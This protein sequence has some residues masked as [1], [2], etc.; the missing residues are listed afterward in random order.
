MY[1]KIIEVGVIFLLMYIPLAFGGVTQSSISL[2]E[3]V[4]GVL[5]IVWLAK[6]LS[7][8]KSVSRNRFLLNNYRLPKALV[9]VAICAFFAV[10]LLQFVPLPGFLV[11]IISPATYRLYAEGALHTG[12]NL[13]NLL[14]LSVCTQATE[15]EFYKFLA[16]TVIFFLIVNTIRTRKQVTRLVYIIL[17]VGLFES[18]YGLL[19]FVS[20]EHLIYS[21]R[22]TWFWVNGTFINKNH[23]A[24][25]LEMVIPLAL[26]VLFTRFEK[27]GSSRLT[28]S[29]DSIREKYPKA[30]LLLLGVLIMIFAL[31]LSGSRGGIISFSLGAIFFALL[32]NT[33][34][35]LRR[36]VVIILIFVPLA[37]GITVI[38][39]QDILIQRLS[40]LTRIETDSSFR[41]RLEFWK[42]AGHIFED[43]P[44]VGSGFGTFAHLSKRYRTFRVQLRH[45]RYP[46]NDYVQ[47]LAETGFVGAS[48]VLLLG[49]AFF[50]QIF[51]TWKRRRSRWAVAMVAG[52][53]SAMFSIAIHS[54][55]DFNLHIPS[56]ALL[57]SVIAALSYVTAHI[58]K[59]RRVEGNT[60][61]SIFPSTGSE[62]RNLQSSI[63]FMV[64]VV[65]AFMFV[66]LYLFYAVNSYYAF[67][68]YQEASKVISQKT[69][70]PVNTTQHDQVIEHLKTAIRHDRNNAEYYYALG[71]YLYRY[72][73]DTQDG[74]AIEHKAQGFH[75]AETWLQKAMRLDPANP[76]YYYEMGRLSDSRGDCPPP[77]S[78]L[79]L[80]QARDRLHQGRRTDSPLPW[81]EGELKEG[82]CPAARYFSAALNNAP[83]EMFLRKE[84][85]RW[86]YYYDQETA[87][88]LLR[89][90][91]SRDRGTTPEH[92]RVSREFSKFLYEIRMDYESDR[93]AAK[94]VDTEK[95]RCKVSVVSQS[96]INLALQGRI[97]FGNDDGSAEWR[98]RLASNTLRVKKVICLPEN[99]AEYDYAALKIFMNHGGNE[100]FIARIS[101]DKHLVKTYDDTAPHIGKWH[102]IP[103][104]KMLLQGKSSIN[105]YI[106]VT[107]ATAAGNYLQIWGDQDTPTTLS[108]FNVDMTNDLSLDEGVQTGEYMIRLVLGTTT[109][110]TTN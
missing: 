89:K 17:A 14:P 46:E 68:H 24:G 54:L 107:G 57:F 71:S 8:Y 97:E 3:I 72:Y 15:G 98:T 96:K 67:T 81:R 33:R 9:P 75:E 40:T 5:L 73:A 34:R 38:I 28:L 12:S 47:L 2:L 20:G 93:E 50:Y 56:N 63:Y 66:L 4:S 53:L 99:L 109:N 22:K 101:I 62:H 42:A 49:L 77:S 84:V 39:G 91:I 36:W 26:G 43:F 10:I 110:S 29:V 51:A 7:Q 48:L 41:V 100:N 25:Y 1:D 19:Q 108:V 13:P 79:S 70:S 30:F 95:E 58:Q 64:T 80:R 76:W 83:N 18:L 90:L 92:P 102:E 31:L 27:P 45:S 23:F 69:P 87:H 32:A 86:Y 103:F 35:L 11:N 106:R 6:V 61:S 37:I 74:E 104:E 16:Y 44:V 88:R 82:D 85:G 55:T 65:L 21:Y 59:S 105:V 52:G 78:V 94:M 60:Q